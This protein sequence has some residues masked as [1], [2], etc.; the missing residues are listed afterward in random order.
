LTDRHGDRGARQLDALQLAQPSI[1]YNQSGSA[2]EDAYHVLA[3]EPQQGRRLGPV[4]QIR[5]R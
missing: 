1:Q 3:I 4:R 5:R 2:A